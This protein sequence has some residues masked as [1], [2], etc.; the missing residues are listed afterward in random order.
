MLTLVNSFEVHGDPARFEE[1]FRKVSDWMRGQPGFHRHQL[2]RSAHDPRRFV[3][4]AVWD[5]QAALDAAIGDEGFQS[6]VAVLRTMATATPH[7]YDHVLDVV[8][9]AAGATP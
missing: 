5:D 6:R 4:I 1:E 7:T 3:N 8:G 2:C 9:T